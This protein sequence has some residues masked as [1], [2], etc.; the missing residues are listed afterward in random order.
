MG[1]RKPIFDFRESN[2]STMAVWCGFWAEG[3]IGPYFFENEIGQAVTVTGAK[4]GVGEM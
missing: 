2:A 4:L 3:I 1:F